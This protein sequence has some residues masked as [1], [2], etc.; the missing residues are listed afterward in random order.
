MA[1]SPKVRAAF[2]RTVRAAKPEAVDAAIVETG[3]A[4]A[5]T[6]DEALVR[7][8]VKTM[9]ISQQLVQVLREMEA[10]PAARRAVKDAAAAVADGA[11]GRLAGLRLVESGRAEAS[12]SG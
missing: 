8:D 2:D 9:W 6:L 5:D 4:L 11:G 1:R 12:A 10:T 7:G 3:R